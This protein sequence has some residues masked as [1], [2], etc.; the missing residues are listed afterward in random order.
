MAALDEEDAGK[1]VLCRTPHLSRFT[2]GSEECRKLM[3]AQMLDLFTRTRAR[4]VAE[5][6]SRDPHGVTRASEIIREEMGLA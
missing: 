5:G 2:A 6:L 4:I 1:C 3:P